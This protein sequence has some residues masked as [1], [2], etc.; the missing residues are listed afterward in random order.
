VLQAD[1][2]TI[3]DVTNG[4]TPPNDDPTAY[5]PAYTIGGSFNSVAEQWITT[6]PTSYPGSTTAYN[7]GA[8]KYSPSTVTALP[9]SI[10]A[11]PA[12]SSGPS[13]AALRLLPQRTLSISA[14]QTLV[15]ELLSLLGVSAN[16]R[17]LQG[18]GVSFSIPHLYLYYL[19][20]KFRHCAK[21]KEIHL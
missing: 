5:S 12:G 20:T 14:S 3:I 16:F 2:P 9:P 10:L 1:A 19:R 4:S 17:F 6:F 13:L 7:A 11:P 21:T 18:V 15:R 8:S